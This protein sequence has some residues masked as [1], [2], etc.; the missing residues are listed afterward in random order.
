[1]ESFLLLGNADTAVR[2]RISAASPG[3]AA[4]RLDWKPT[5]S[6]MPVTTVFNVLDVLETS[7]KTHGQ[8]VSALRIHD[9]QNTNNTCDNKT[10]S[11]QSAKTTMARTTTDSR[12]EDLRVACLRVESV[13]EMKTPNTGAIVTINAVRDVEATA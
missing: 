1:M 13:Q 9:H 4:L 10:Q 6:T 7:V 12:R 8:A 5:L 2:L 3:T 11:I